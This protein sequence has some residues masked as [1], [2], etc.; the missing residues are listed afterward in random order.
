MTTAELEAR[1]MTHDEMVGLLCRLEDA[2]YIPPIT[3]T[4]EILHRMTIAERIADRL[5]DSLFYARM[6]KDASD[7]GRTRR[8]EMID[9]AVYLISLF[10]NGGLYP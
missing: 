10:R 2:S 8:E 4:R 7:D 1:N 3:I 6:Y 9:D 5:E